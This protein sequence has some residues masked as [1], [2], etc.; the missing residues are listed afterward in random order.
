[1]PDPR[2][3]S[4]IATIF[5]A[6]F[7]VGVP[8][9]LGQSAWEKKQY[10][11]SRISGLQAQIEQ[12]RQREGVLS[13]EIDN[14]S[15]RIDGLA[16]RIGDLSSTLAVLERELAA[17]RDRLARLRTQFEEQTRH[18]QRLRQQHQVAQRRLGERLVQLY[19]TSETTELDVLFQAESLVDLIEQLDYFNQIGDQD[20]RIAE[21]LARLKVEMR[22][23]RQKTARLKAEVGE[24]TAI[25]ARKTEE[26]RA[27]RAALLA[28]QNALAAARDSKESLLANV[29][30]DRHEA[31]ED[32][33]AMQ[34]ASASLGAQIRSSQGSS[35][36]PS[37]GSSGF[38][39]PVNGVLTSGFGWRWGRMHEGIDISAPCGTPVR[40]VA[41]GNVIFSGWM[42]GYGNL[43]VL[44][45]GGGIATAYAHLSASY[46]GGGVG[47]G[48]T[49]GAVGT[50]GSSTGCH[51]HFEVRINGSPVDPMGYL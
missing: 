47:Q 9:A 42:G 18:L 30:E 12:A 32:L 15:S 37:G 11:D 49:I 23:A 19:E 31:E 21:T 27:A 36:P 14:A 48:Q 45:H 28:Q 33:A 50:T 34:A 38:V 20:K 7:V 6:A 29:E 35:P 39:W 40:A 8:S 24:A 13:A 22:I 16:G 26:Q 1:V 46:A 4:L 17:H 5:A 44:D 2:R 51:L 25:L 3:L 41:A 43:I 10:V